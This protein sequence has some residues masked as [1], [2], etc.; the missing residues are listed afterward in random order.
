M[1]HMPDRHL[2]LSSVKHKRQMLQNDE[3]HKSPHIVTEPFAL[4]V[5][6]RFDRLFRKSIPR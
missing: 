5:F 2:A 3:W 6:P 1:V 4:P